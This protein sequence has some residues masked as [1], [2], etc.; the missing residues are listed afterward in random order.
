MGSRSVASY[1]AEQERIARQIRRYGRKT[2]E[3]GKTRRRRIRSAVATGLVESGLHNLSGGDADSA[4]WRQERSSLYS[5]PTNVKAGIRRYF[6]EA[7]ALDTGQSPG[8]LA[9]DVQRPAAQY[10]GRYAAE[11]GEAKALLK[12]L[13][14]GGGNGG[15]RQG[16][17]SYGTRTTTTTDPA[18]TRMAKYSYLQNRDDP[19]A[20][21]TLASSLASA[22]QTTTTPIPGDFANPGR[23]GKTRTGL[24]GKI[25]HR[26]DRIDSK[27]FPYEW[28]GGHNPA[29]QK[30]AIPLDCSGAV[31][32]VLGIDPRV[33]G[34][35]ASWGKPGK[36][37]HVTIYANDH[38]VL[39]EIGG[40][41]WG[42]SGSNPGGGAGW[43]PA[44]AVSS[45]YLAG[46]TARHPKGL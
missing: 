25:E 23:G 16:A 30:Q 36:G 7:A 45:S 15:A 27:Q 34:Q 5:N 44:S 4:G 35:L 39:M 46:F 18:A 14:P 41:F 10:R 11:M 29:T 8:E 21:L 38:H 1:D 9:A 3:P 26:A 28:G 6:R 31:S 12:Q 20:L 24:L 13:G 43:I 17:Q 37:K 22:V 32:K 33:S 42:T 2:I 19:D 40:R